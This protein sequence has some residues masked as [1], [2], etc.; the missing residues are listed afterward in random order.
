MEA[1]SATAT[2]RN[3]LCV[4]A[5]DLADIADVDG[6]ALGILGHL[7]GFDQ[8]AVDAADTN[9]L[10]ALAAENGNDLLV[11]LADEDHLGITHCLFV[12]VPQAVYEMGFLADFI[13]HA[14]NVGSAAMNDDGV[15][16]DELE[17][18]NVIHD[19]LLKFFIDHCVSAILDDEGLTAHLL[20]VRK[21]FDEDR[22]P[23]DIVLHVSRDYG[24]LFLTGHVIPP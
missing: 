19:G 11:G 14:G 2:S 16:A 17:E 23:V 9:S 22:S 20:D 1:P 21:R 24:C 10:C 12:G 15:D 8:I 18:R 7:L 13:E 6:V 4:D 5:C 3:D